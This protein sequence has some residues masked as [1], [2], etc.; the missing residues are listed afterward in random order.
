MA[1]APLAPLF[2]PP[3]WAVIFTS[4]RTDG[5]R[6]YGAMAGEME[7]LV[8]EQPGFLGMEH[9]R[10]E[11]GTGITAAYFRT[12][13]D[14]RAWKAVARHREAQRLG[15]EQWYRAYR[16]R[17]AKVEREYGWEAG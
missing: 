4:L 2:E 9:A 6:G 15:R 11:D 3:Y 16:V 14:A 7:R 8:K 5:D 12:E 13:A 10:S 17:V 1:D